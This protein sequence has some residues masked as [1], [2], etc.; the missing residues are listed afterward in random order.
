[1]Y[2]LLLVVRYVYFAIIHAY[3]NWETKVTMEKHNFHDRPFLIEFTKNDKTIHQINPQIIQ[4]VSIL[5]Q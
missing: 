3:I 1:V 5:Q 4:M 2:N